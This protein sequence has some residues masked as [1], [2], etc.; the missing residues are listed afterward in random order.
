MKSLCLDLR[1]GFG[2]STALL[3]LT[4]VMSA[5]RLNMIHHHLP[6]LS[7][8]LVFLPL[9]SKSINHKVSSLH[10]S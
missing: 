6:Q 1:S 2:V 3:H 9:L 4:T 8:D 5:L 7:T 10:P